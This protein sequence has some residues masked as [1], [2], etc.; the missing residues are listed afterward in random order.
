M[1][2]I[3][4]QVVVLSVIVAALLISGAT[5]AASAPASDVAKPASRKGENAAMTRITALDIY[6]AGAKAVFSAQMGENV[7]ME[8]PG[9]FDEASVRAVKKPGQNINY[10]SVQRV[11]N[12]GT[13]PDSLKELHGELEEKKLRMKVLDTQIQ[14]AT[15][16]LGLLG[17]IPISDKMGAADVDI[18]LNNIMQNRSRISIELNNLNVEK[19]KLALEISQLTKRYSSELPPKHDSVIVVNIGAEGKGAIDVE[20][21]TT[22]A[23]WKPKYDMNFDTTRG[24]ITSKMIAE[25]RLNSGVIYEGAIKFY[26]NQPQSTSLVVPKINR[27]VVTFPPEYKPPAPS[28]RKEYS[29]Q[30]MSVNARTEVS[31]EAEEAP[32]PPPKPVVAESPV[33]AV[34]TGNGRIVSDNKPVSVELGA[35]TY[36]TKPFV[37]MNRDF[38]RNGLLMAQIDNIDE[39]ILPGAATMY[40][41]DQFSGHTTV[42]YTGRGETMKLA[43][44]NAPLIKI[45]KETDA[46][47][48]STGMF[49]SSGIIQS[50]YS[51][52]A[53]NGSGMDLDIELID[54]IPFSVN[55]KIVVEQV[56]VNPAPD[57]NEDNVMTWKFHL[58]K[59]ES[60]KFKVQY[61][62]KHPG[63]KE[64]FYQ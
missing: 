14:A 38:S 34:I 12:P 63:D 40:V 18:L 27:L 5:F 48:S 47:Y 41:D 3:K 9:A 4:K 43:V 45:N 31:A 54:R 21:F 52:E 19:E 42:A 46:D 10:F 53:V 62:I 15:A 44:G 33:N 61:R 36:K 16:N 8:I 32:P 24:E 58:K 35:A 55:E 59:G 39:P 51:L 23:S 28:V 50:G 57:K 60:R 13:V 11:N 20:A 2:R 1:A 30:M 56:T 17:N 22:Y 6:P 37:I 26:T 25:A 49:S 7:T 29:N 64:L